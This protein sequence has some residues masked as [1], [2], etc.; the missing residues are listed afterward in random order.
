MTTAAPPVTL[1]EG[2]GDPVALPARWTFWA[3][4]SV[5]PYAPIG[6]VSVQSF[7]CMWALSGFGN[8][9]AVIPVPGNVMGRLDLLKFY[10]WRLWAYYGQTLV[11]GG[12]ATGLVDDG[13]PVVTVSLV[14]LPGYLNVKQYATTRT[15]S[16]VEQT[17][18]A[19]DL[20]ARLDNIGVPRLL[21]PGP[22]KLRDRTYTYLQ[23][24]SRGDLLTQLCQVQNGPEMRSE[25]APDVNGKP[26]CTLHIAYP[27]VGTGASGLALVVPGGATTFQSTWASDQYRTRTF[28]VGDN[29]PGASA[30]T[31]KPSIIVSQPQAGVP[32]IDHV[33]DWP[34]VTDTAT[35]TDRANTNA[36]VYGS[37]SF[38]VTATVPVNAPPLGTYAIGD[39]VA[40]AL[41]DPLVPAG[42]TT[43]GRL[44]GAIADAAAGTVAWTVAI[45]APPPIHRSLT[46]D[47]RRIDRHLTNVMHQNLGTPPGG[48]NP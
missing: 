42:Y 7:S 29:P 15:Y 5:A 16:Q 31:P 40:V 8:A 13:G 47:L 26:T 18:I 11:W 21:T 33:D 39:D 30:S 2:I 6:A 25:Y 20:A 44:V 37:P 32:E 17:T 19:G 48:T 10:G 28:S 46:T 9:E 3:D 43:M 27:R 35:L 41:A 14:E 23:G 36:A 1:P 4:G 12:M 45:T 38:T 22:G 24:Q 34:G